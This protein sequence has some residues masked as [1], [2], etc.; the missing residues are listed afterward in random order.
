MSCRLPAGSRGRPTGVWDTGDPASS[1]GGFARSH[2]NHR[3]QHA[4]SKM[5]AISSGFIVPSEVTLCQGDDDP[6]EVASWEGPVTKLLRF[7]RMMTALTRPALG[8]VTARPPGARG[9]CHIPRP[10][11]GRVWGTAARGHLAVTCVPGGLG[12]GC[13]GGLGEVFCLPFPRCCLT[14]KAGQ[15]FQKPLSAGE[16]AAPAPS[17]P[18][19]SR[20]PA[21]LAHCH[22]RGVHVG[23]LLPWAPCAHPSATVSRATGL[24]HLPGGTSVAEPRALRPAR[25][26]A[27]TSE[28]SREGT[29]PG[30]ASQRLADVPRPLGTA[31]PRGVLKSGV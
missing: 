1:A 27:H 10:G 8:A 6:G 12:R 30:S 22:S 2:T 3:E 31:E 26:S 15:F 14:N 11:S 23:T 9:L 29:D 28:G 13:G 20:R 19:L 18:E 7:A 24:P 4:S 16:L 5:T 25:S 21:S 17:S